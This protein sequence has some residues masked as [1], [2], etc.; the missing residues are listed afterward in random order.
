MLFKNMDKVVTKDGLLEVTEYHSDNALR[1]AITKLK[2]LLN[3]EIKHIRGVG[4]TIESC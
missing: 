3:I 4:Y 1:V 2:T